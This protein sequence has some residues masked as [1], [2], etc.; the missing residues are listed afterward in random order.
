[1]CWTI[2]RKFKTSNNKIFSKLYDVILLPPVTVAA[3]S[4]AWVC[5]RLLA[6]IVG[7]R[8]PPGAFNIFCGCCHVEASAT[9]RSHVQRSPTDFVS[10]CV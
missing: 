5:G 3:P 10:V 2:L 8:I 9:G 4:N 7:I 1:M 6:G